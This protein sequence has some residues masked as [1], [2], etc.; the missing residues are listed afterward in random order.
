MTIYNIKNIFDQAPDTDT[1]T[2]TNTD[3]DTNTDTDTDTNMI[4]I[5][6]FNKKSS[7]D[8]ETKSKNYKVFK[9]I[10]NNTI[11]LHQIFKIYW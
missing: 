11:I 6:D 5:I 8:I 4:L 2:D 10:K 1:D 3:N 7:K 9:V